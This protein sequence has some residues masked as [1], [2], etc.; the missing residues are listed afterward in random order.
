[1]EWKEHW[2]GSQGV[3]I[4]RAEGVLGTMESHSRMNASPF[5]ELL[6]RTRRG[7]EY[8]VRALPLSWE[9]HW[10]LEEGAKA[11]GRTCPGSLSPRTQTWGEPRRAS[12]RGGPLPPSA[13]LVARGGS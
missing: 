8:S 6:L 11:Q 4:T 1:M 2:T 5:P 7:S 10:V 12:P 13:G 9:W 3:G